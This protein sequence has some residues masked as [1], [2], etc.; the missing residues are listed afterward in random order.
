MFRLAWFVA[1]AIFGYIA[2]GYVEGLM[3]DGQKE[4]A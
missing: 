4:E 2:S 1:G 3:D